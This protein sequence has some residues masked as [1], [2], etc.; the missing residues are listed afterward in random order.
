MRSQRAGVS[1]RKGSDR[2]DACS[3]EG[4]REDRHGERWLSASQGESLRRKHTR[5]HLDS[6]LPASRTKG[7]SVC[8]VKAPR[9]VVFGY[10]GAGTHVWHPRLDG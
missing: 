1:V 8:V 3:G 2:R 7:K 4:L 10:G 9:S 5:P 6:R